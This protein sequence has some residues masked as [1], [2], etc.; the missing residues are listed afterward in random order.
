MKPI[1]ESNESHIARVCGD[2]HETGPTYRWSRNFPLGLVLLAVGV[3]LI[4][5][6]VGLATTG[7]FASYTDHI[8]NLSQGF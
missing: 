1:G 8:K 3:M 6:M 4:G 5:V 2:V 7:M